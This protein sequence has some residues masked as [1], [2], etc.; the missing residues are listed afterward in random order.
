M[1]AVHHF[2]VEY[3]SPN[4]LDT[5]SV[6]GKVG[7]G[8]EASTATSYSNKILIMVSLITRAMSSVVY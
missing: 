4:A 5:C 1:G 2:S 8:V 7:R 3:P 6:A